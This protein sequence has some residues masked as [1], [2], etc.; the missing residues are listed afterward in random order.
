MA[1]KSRKAQF[2][3]QI[4]E[5]KVWQVEKEIKELKVGDKI[6]ARD[7]EFVWGV[8]TVLLVIEVIDKPALVTIHFE[9]FKSSKD[10]CLSLKSPRL[11]PFGFYTSKFDIP[12]YFIP[13][14]QPAP[15]VAC[16]SNQL[17]FFSEV[18]ELKDWSQ[19]QKFKAQRLKKPKLE[20]F[21][22]ESEGFKCDWMKDFLD[23]YQEDVYAE[24]HHLQFS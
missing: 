6:D 19:L 20:D 24:T 3:S 2:E 18:T 7:Q 17:N 10:E 15:A 8:A 11:A 23:Q 14:P 9:G 12:R 5:Y 4:R 22:K 21:S 13:N 16:K 1:A